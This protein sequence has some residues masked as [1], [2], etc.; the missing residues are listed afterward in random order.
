MSFENFEFKIVRTSN[1]TL[2]PQMILY[3]KFINYK[4]VELIEI[5]NFGFGPF[6]IRVCLD[7][8]EKWISKYENIK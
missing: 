2:G 4:I 8:S 5:Y 3:E 1:I 6:S 7:I